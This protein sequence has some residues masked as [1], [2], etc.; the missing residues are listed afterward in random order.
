MAR[1][2]RDAP[3]MNLAARGL[4]AHR[5]PVRSRGLRIHTVALR[6]D[7][8]GLLGSGVPRHFRTRSSGLPAT[9]TAGRHWSFNEDVEEFLMQVEPRRMDADDSW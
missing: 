6:L 1:D 9:G 3:D 2:K 4:N 7:N 5:R 8:G